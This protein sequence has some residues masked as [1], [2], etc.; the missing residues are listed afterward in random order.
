MPFSF[1]R[2]M[3]KQWEQVGAW[4]IILIPLSGLFML[5][6]ALRRLAYRLGLFRS[7]KIPVPVIVVG[8]ISVGGTGKTPLVVWLAERLQQQ[9]YM[10]AVVSRGYGGTVSSVTPVFKDSD[11]AFA[12]DEPVLVARRGSWPVWV[13]RNRVAVAQA[14]LRAHPECNVILSDDGLQHY[15]LRR[16]IELTVVDAERG[17]G[18][19]LRLPAGPLREGKGRLKTV[20]AVVSHGGN[21]LP[22]S[23]SMYLVG[24]SFRNIANPQNIAA[25]DD[26][27]GQ[28][29]VAVAGIGHPSRFFSKL[30]DMGL[31][32]RE[33]AF[34]DH[35]AFQPEDLQSL[36]AGVILMTEKDA[37]KCAAFAE[38]NWWYLPVDA[39]VDEAL[40]T[41]I[42]NKLRNLNGP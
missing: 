30:K 3:R 6:S 16:D 21:V 14:A 20:D 8:N 17:F 33:V 9:G 39:A 24:E 36:G 31:Q 42:L 29:I 38:S 11:P 27:A 7:V 34:P 13:G 22:G 10:P 25:A 5:L 35:Y 1:E 37:V 26:F 23:Y 12:G 4:H 19:G 18:N 28:Q 32:F 15:A 40:S 2:F 41:Y